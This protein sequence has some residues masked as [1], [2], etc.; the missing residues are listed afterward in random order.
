M[1]IIPAGRG[2]GQ[3]LEHSLELFLD[4]LHDLGDERF[5]GVKVMEEHPCARSDGGGQRAQGK[6]GDAV[7]EKV[8]A[9]APEQIDSGVYVTT[10]T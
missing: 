8:G 5:L 6:V 2:S 10:V 9:A 4:L 3:V 7:P 1:R